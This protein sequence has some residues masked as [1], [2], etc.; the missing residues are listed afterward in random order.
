L[1]WLQQHIRQWHTALVSNPL[2]PGDWSDEVA[3]TFNLAFE[4]LAQPEY[5]T[6]SARERFSEVYK[7]YRALFG[8]KEIE[9]L[10]DSVFSKY[11]LGQ[12]DVIPDAIREQALLEL[13]DRAARHMVGISYERSVTEDELRRALETKGPNPK[14]V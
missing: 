12:N 14:Q 13:F 6:A 11:G 7:V 8:L 2:D 1:L 5:N 4:W 3:E 9:R 10:S